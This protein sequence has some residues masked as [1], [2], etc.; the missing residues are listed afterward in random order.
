MPYS[1]N[2]DWRT[3][4]GNVAPDFHWSGTDDAYNM[5]AQLKAEVERN[6]SGAVVVADATRTYNCHA[7]VHASAHAWFNDIS[8]FLQDDYYPF[9]PGTLQIND[10]VVYVKDGQITHSGFIIQLSGNTILRVRSKWGAY[11]RV[12]HPPTSVPSIYGSI[13]YYLRRRSAL[14]ETESESPVH[15]DSRTAEVLLTKLLDSERLKDLW[16]ASTPEVAQMI[17]SQWPE[18]TE[19]VMHASAVG[20]LVADKLKKYESAE[21]PIL[22]ALAKRIQ[23]RDVFRTLAEQTATYAERDVTEDEQ[24]VLDTFKALAEQAMDHRARQASAV[25]L[26]K[27]FLQNSELR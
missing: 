14:M 1:P 11:P 5:R 21:L 23:S 8:T 26:A 22:L 20:P 7:F 19:S 3:S 24:M 9:T 10:A 16:L 4:K 13:T 15:Q 6:Y 27:R 12:E 25:D 18:F 2:S 17:I